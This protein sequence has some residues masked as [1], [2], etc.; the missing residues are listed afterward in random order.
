MTYKIYS[1]E[2]AMESF[3]KI[4]KQAGN[5][6]WSAGEQ[7]SGSLLQIIPDICKRVSQFTLDIFAAPESGAAFQVGRTHVSYR[8]VRSESSSIYDS[9]GRD[10][11]LGQCR[12]DTSALTG[13]QNLRISISCG[14]DRQFF[15]KGHRGWLRI[16][17]ITFTLAQAAVGTSVHI[18]LRIQKSQGIRLHGYG[19]MRANRIACGAS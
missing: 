19:L 3:G 17:K 16:D 13:F 6:A 1:N 14:E 9:S 5:L 18:H 15:R 4:R 10:Y 7:Y 11:S 2:I 12:E 8:E